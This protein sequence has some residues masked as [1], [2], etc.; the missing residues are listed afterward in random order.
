MKDAYRIARNNIGKSQVRSK[1][2]YDRKV[3][4]TSLGC[5]DLVLVKKVTFDEGK[6]KLADKWEDKPYEVL[7]KMDGSPVYEVRSQSGKGR[8]RKLH[9]NMLL[10]IGRKEDSSTSESEE[11]D[12]SYGYEER[13][14]IGVRNGATEEVD[15]QRRD[16]TVEEDEERQEDRNEQEREDAED[17]AEDSEDSEEEQETEVV[18]RRSNRI[19]GPPEKFRSGDYV[20]NFLGS[21]ASTQQDKMVLVKQ[22][23]DF[24][25]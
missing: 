24:L 2:R 23:L 10:P 21:V 1:A 22:L 12:E 13:R 8:I 11:S 15:L 9:R 25:K 20:T 16:D 19:R 17:S 7:K 5:G 4:G 14:E 6:H 3:K 18:P